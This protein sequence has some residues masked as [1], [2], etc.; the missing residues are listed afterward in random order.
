MFKLIKYTIVLGL[1]VGIVFLGFKINKKSLEIETNLAD[2]KTR[3]KKKIAELEK[4]AI[5]KTLALGKVYKEINDSLDSVE[6]KQ[7][8]IQDDKGT[9]K[10]P[11]T[12]LPA[13]IISEPA[14]SLKPIDEEDRKVTTEVLAEVSDKKQAPKEDMAESEFRNQPLAPENILFEE[15]P[16]EPLDIKRVTEIRNVYSKAIETLDLK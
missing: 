1:M 5:K 2:Q 3:A 11:A 16:I 10:E 9:K 4:K 14:V 8:N 13:K 7:T 15:E 12:S 6:V